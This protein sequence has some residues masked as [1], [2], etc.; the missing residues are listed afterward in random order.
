MLIVHIKKYDQAFLVL[1]LLYKEVSAKD[2]FEISFQFISIKEIN[3]MSLEKE[4]VKKKQIFL[5]TLW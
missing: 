1:Q 3:I 5:Y 2:E 4:K